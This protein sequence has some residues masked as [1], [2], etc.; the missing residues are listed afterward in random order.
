MRF[1][2][3]QD[4][5]VL[6][7]CLA[8]F[9]AYADTVEPVQVHPAGIRVSILTCSAGEELYSTYGHTAVRI[10]DSVRGTDKVYNYG[11]FDFGD[12]D[13][14]W[15]FT[16]GK[17][18]YFVAEDNYPMFMREYI[19]DKRGVQEQVLQLQRNQAQT[20]QDFLLNNIKEENKYYH[21]DFLF[22]NCSTRIRD[23]LQKTLGTG[24]VFGRV[25]AD[26]SVSFRTYLNEYERNLHWERVGIN[27]LM[28]DQVDNN[29]TNEQSF[30]LPDF[31]MRGIGGANLN[32][33]P[34]VKETLQLLPAPFGIQHPAN[35]PRLLF[36]GI[37][38]VVVLASFIPSFKKKLIYF[39]FLFFLILGL[40]G[41][42]MLFMWFGTDHKVC[43]WNRNLLWAF[44]LHV[45]F[46]ILLL[47]KSELAAEY[48][49]YASMLLGVSVVY[50]FFAEQAY[51]K[52]ITPIILLLFIR[53]S[54]YS[55]RVQMIQN[56]RGF[57]ANRM[58]HR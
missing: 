37:L 11:T 1:R 6:L 5:I 14:Y 46:A 17:L 39:D 15:K 34:L 50:S 32:G 36:W 21:Y 20:I 10:I 47:R 52:E 41:C 44:P 30:F 28:S 40:L 25:I 16:R 48:A 35:Q 45:V 8:T 29:M 54:T 43:A 12:P 57:Q 27:V 33:Q 18:L 19:Y 7:L 26:D 31:L 3:L 38:L 51:I 55:K 4:I 13:F 42:F 53:L 56:L 49:K 24:L 23:L 58:G 22:D 2:F 9:T